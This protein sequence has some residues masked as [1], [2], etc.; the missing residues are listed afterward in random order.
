MLLKSEIISEYDLGRVVIA[1]F[2]AES[3]GPN[4][5]DVRLGNQLAVYTSLPLDSRAENL[6]EMFTIPEEGWVLQ[7]GIL[8][9]GST[10]E[11]I[12]SDHYIPMYEGRS[13]MARLGIQS[14][15]S[16]GFGDVGFKSQWTLEISVIHPVR[17]YAG[18]RIGQVYFNCI[19]SV[20]NLI[21]NRY[22]GKY[23]GQSGPQTSKSYMDKK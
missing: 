16:A 13:S 12:G 14:H 18:D 5:Y 9:L 21:T 19:N 10:V 1:P 22:T 6:S 11:E 17:I 23:S 4:S 15:L 7:P 8:Y 2:D 3:V 20:A